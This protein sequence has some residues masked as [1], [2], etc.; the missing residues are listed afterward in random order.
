MS[1]F[2]RVPARIYKKW[3]Q[4]VEIAPKYI[5]LYTDLPG[6][7]VQKES[8]QIYC[9]EGELSSAFY[10]HHLSFLV[11][12]GISFGLVSVMKVKV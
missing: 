8:S 4:H 12:M 10:S 6:T 9:N 11:G 5:F 7:K 2:V 3:Y 1:F